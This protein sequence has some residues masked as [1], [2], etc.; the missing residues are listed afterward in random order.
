MV[1][2]NMFNMGLLVIIS[3]L[4]AAVFISGCTQQTATPTVTPTSTTASI[5]TSANRTVVDMAGRT[6]TLPAQIH[7]IIPLY[8]P[9][10]EKLVILGSENLIS[11]AADYDKTNSAWAHI[12][13]PRMDLLPVISN[14]TAPNVENLLTYHPDVVFYFGND[15]NVGKMQNAGI[16]VIC[17]VGN[18]TTLD[19]DKTLLNLYAQVIGTPAALQK[20]Q[21][22]DTYFDQKEAYVMNVTSAMPD[23]AKPKVYVV[24]GIPLRTKGGQSTMSDT[25]SKAGGI[26]VAQNLTAG[27]DVVSYEQMLAWNPDI[28]VIDHAPDLPDPSASSTSNTSAASATYEQIMNDPNLQNINAVKNHQVYISPQGAFFWDAGEQGILQLQWMAKLFHPAQFQNLNMTTEV[29][30][31]YSEFFNYNLTDNQT[32]AILNHQLPPNATQWGYA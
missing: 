26:D 29:Q 22:Y 17:S 8:G 20:A 2:K 13:Y 23:S 9:A 11:V 30:N 27:T 5:S 4:L 10:Y 32:N 18:T 6:V 28:I 15:Q 21:A 1:R 3:I 24:S 25:V 16:P 19:W 7:S 14:P 12:I 31:F